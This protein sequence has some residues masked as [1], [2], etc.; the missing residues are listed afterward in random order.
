MLH[1]YFEVAP[2]I[3]GAIW[4]EMNWTLPC[5][6]GREEK[7]RRRQ[8]QEQ[9]RLNEVPI[10][11]SESV[12]SDITVLRAAHL[13]TCL[14]F[15]QHLHSV[16]YLSW[17]RISESTCEHSLCK[18]SRLQFVLSC[19]YKGYAVLALSWHVIIMTSVTTMPGFLESLGTWLF[20][21]AAI[22]VKQISHRVC[23][24]IESN[25]QDKLASKQWKEGRASQVLVAPKLLRQ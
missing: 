4:S 18:L 20:S 5:L 16:N 6:K 23:F 21:L 14:V 22:H 11:Q 24:V 19:D 17:T 10:R 25:K 1:A 2:K 3:F 7:Q 9:W 13:V 12:W 8:C 15:I